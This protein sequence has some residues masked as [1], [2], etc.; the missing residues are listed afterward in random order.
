MQQVPIKP[1]KPKN[2]LPAPRFNSKLSI[3]QD[4]Y[5][6]LPE[7]MV[8]NY[9]C[10]YYQF[11]TVG[12]Q[13][14]KD[15]YTKFLEHLQTHYSVQEYKFEITPNNKMY[16]LEN[17]ERTIFVII[18]I[19]QSDI[20]GVSIFSID[21]QTAQEVYEVF[22]K[23]E[24]IENDTIVNFN[25]LSV[26]QNGKVSEYNIQYKVSD[27]NDDSPLFYPYLD[28]DELFRQF[29]ISEENILVISGAPGTGK[30][31]AVNLYIKYL[32]ENVELCL[33]HGLY[34][35]DGDDSSKNS[36]GVCYVK[37]EELLSTDGLWEIL[38]IRRP[39]IVF[40]DDSDHS[41]T[42][43]NNEVLTNED[44]LKNKFLSQLLS[45]TDG[46]TKNNVKFIITTNLPVESIDTAVLR[47]GRT[48]DIL[49]FQT[50]SHDEAMHIWTEFGLE[51]KNFYKYFSDDESFIP[52]C[53]LGSNISKEKAEINS[54]IQNRTYVL[55]D[56]ISILNKTSK[57]VNQGFFG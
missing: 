31:R 4:A 19:E 39:A 50:L 38:T 20:Y 42:S 24:H 45:F 44:H 15:N 12:L 48:F 9:I 25:T 29:T 11:S 21:I 23:Y 52:A 2:L 51:E 47:K 37:N 7:A 3:L 18:D 22:K 14:K 56:G 5:Q 10:S 41:L 34:E 6:D 32:L 33:E 8:N 35:N 13:C 53:D 54:G 26:G 28:T 43:R 46:I 16:Y 55:R 57:K 49:R 27:F 36:I 40:L 30:T 1:I 17:A